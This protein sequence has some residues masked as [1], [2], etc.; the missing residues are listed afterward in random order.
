MHF[1]IFLE[2]G[3]ELAGHENVPQRP[4]VENPWP[5]NK[6]TSSLPSPTF[7]SAPGHID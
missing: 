3:E 6:D 2:S 4:R 7:H 5:T 1:M